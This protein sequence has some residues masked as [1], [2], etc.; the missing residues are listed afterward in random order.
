M[1]IRLIL[2]L[3]AAL[4]GGT[5]APALAA[6]PS[7]GAGMY[8]W[9]VSSGPSGG[10]A[11]STRSATKT[12]PPSRKKAHPK[13]SGRKA[14]ST[15]SRPKRPSSHSGPFW[16]TL[17]VGDRG[18]DV[19]TLQ[20]WLT[21]VGI[22][23]GVDGVYGSGTRG[24]VMRF[25]LAAHLAPDGIAGP[26]TEAALQAWI[27]EGKV[28]PTQGNVGSGAPAGWVFPLSPVS[29]V[30]PP[31]DWTLD[32]GVD[33]GTWGNACGSSVVEVAV[34]NGTIVQEGISGFGPYAPVLKVATGPL[35]GRYVYYGHAAPALV[36]VGTYVKAGQPI[37]EVGC[38]IVGISD[39][40]HLEIGISA[41]GG[42][43]CCPT[44][45][46]TAGLMDQIVRALYGS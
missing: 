35:A 5:C 39:A 30:L 27:R 11:A 4:A 10:T 23:T 7:G 43:P 26:M 42:P 12:K 6:D 24:S 37:A 16:R 22:P 45:G 19:R 8:P 40:P 38:G 3:T 14:R 1:R 29:R 44:L 32:Q 36:P 18:T 20:S 33:I 2:I 9:A 46:E 13:P 41:P 25:Q 17:K 21:K 31:S 15:P 34:T 28:V